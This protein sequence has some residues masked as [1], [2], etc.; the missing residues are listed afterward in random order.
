MLLELELD[1]FDEYRTSL[2]EQNLFVSSF[3]P[4][5]HYKLIEVKPRN[6]PLKPIGKFVSADKPVAFRAKHI[7]DRDN[8]SIGTHVHGFLYGASGQA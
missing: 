3:R 5:T 7:A 1:F 2:I 4:R 6:A 8:N